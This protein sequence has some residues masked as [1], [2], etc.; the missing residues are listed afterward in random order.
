MSLLVIAT[1]ALAASIGILSARRRIWIARR[2]HQRTQTL[3]AS[4]PEG[5]NFWFVG[6][7]ARLTMG[8]RWLWAAASWLAWTV[9]GMCL[10]ALGV[11][12]L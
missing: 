8:T 11:R 12:L 9:A 1:G 10:I 2:A 5:W 3:Y 6:G 7:F 4:I